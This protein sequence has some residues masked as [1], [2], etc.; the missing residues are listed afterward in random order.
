MK[1]ELIQKALKM[2]AKVSRESTSWIGFYESETP[3]D[4]QK[5]AVPKIENMCR[6]E[7]V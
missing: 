1:K 5:V 7:H 2:I 4:L 3:Q 6:I